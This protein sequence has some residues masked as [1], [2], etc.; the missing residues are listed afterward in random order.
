MEERILDCL[1]G[2]T[3]IQHNREAFRNLLRNGHLD[4]RLIEI[5]VP[6][7]KQNFD[8]QGQVDALKPNPYPHA[9]LTRNLTLTLTPA[10]T[11]TLTPAPTLTLTPTL[12]LK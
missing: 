12:T 7:K 11:L 10:P 8:P 5:E 4:D 9:P 6:E 3:N 2:T 1:V